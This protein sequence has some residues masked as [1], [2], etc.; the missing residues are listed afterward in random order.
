MLGEFLSANV[1]APF[2]L[3]MVE[4]KFP[5]CVCYGL[6][7]HPQLSQASTNSRMKQMLDI[8]QAF[9]VRGYIGCSDRCVHIFAFISVDVLPNPVLDITTLGMAHSSCIL[10]PVTQSNTGYRCGETWITN[11][12]ICCFV[13]QLHYLWSVRHIYLNTTS[14]SYPFNARR[15]RW[16][17]WGRSRICHRY[18]G[19]E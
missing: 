16:S 4:G 7:S 10:V 13:G 6:S 5:L 2:L 12:S 15:I 9:S 11:R 1:S 17:N 18:H 8:G 14:Y 19:S 3:F